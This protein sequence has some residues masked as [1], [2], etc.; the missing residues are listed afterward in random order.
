MRVCQN[1]GA[2]LPVYARSNV[3]TCSTRCRV[4]LHRASKRQDWRF[5][6]VF[7]E[8]VFPEHWAPSPAR[9]VWRE[10]DDFGLD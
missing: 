2:A 8:H 3:R 4:A 1:C 6:A 9:V 5:A 7:L 10:S